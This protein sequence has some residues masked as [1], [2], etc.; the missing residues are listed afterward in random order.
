[1]RQGDHCVIVDAGHGFGGDHGVDDRFFGGLDCCQKNWIERIVGEHG[2]LV[3]SFGADSAGIRGGEGD[4]N[5]AGAVT[6]IAAVA[7][8]AEGNLSGDA[9][10]LRGD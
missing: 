8:Q 1:M 9:L 2:E 3:E 7:A 10:E 6:G 4:E 5:I